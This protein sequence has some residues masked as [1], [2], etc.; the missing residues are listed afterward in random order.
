MMRHIRRMCYPVAALAVLTGPLTSFST[1][2]AD[3]AGTDPVRTV[4]RAAPDPASCPQRV[5]LVNGG[6]EQPAVTGG[7]VGFFPDASQNGVPGWVTTA[8]DHQIEL[9]TGPPNPTNAAPAEGRQFAELNANQVSTLYQ[10]H[11]TTP[12]A[13]LYWRLSHRGRLGVDT[14][15]LDI[16]APGSPVRQRTVSD[17]ATGWGA[18]TGTYTVPAGQTTT[19]FAFTSLSAAGGN[20]GIGNFL[21]DVFFGTAPC[22]VVTKTAIPDGPADVGDVITYRLTARNDGGAPA[23]NVRLTDA[24]PAGTSYLPGSLRVVDGPNT[25][26]KTDQ[27]GDDQGTFD[28]V[29][30]QVSFSLGAGATGSA[31]GR[32]PSTADLPDGT[33]VEFR[34]R[35][36][37]A[38]AGGRIVNQGGVSYDNR[39]GATPEPLRS[40]SGEIVT[41]VNPA[42]DLSVVKSADLTRV[43]VGQTVTYRLSV[44]NAGPNDA[45]GVAVADALPQGL[46]FVSAT[47]SSGAYDPATG[48]WTVGGLPRG[49][50]ATLTI[51]AKATAP[52]KE[53]NTATVGGNELDLDPA[54]DS[55]AVE[56]CV[57]PPPPC[58][59]CASPRC[60]TCAP[61]PGR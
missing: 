42:V 17:D 58:R 24:V 41:R 46:T 40:T 10:D 61:D 55:D 44:R 8:T 52:G 49:G 20:R 27:P 45:T 6:F 29:A 37:R 47:P 25:G 36:G 23:E 54:N 4:R 43:T 11:P 7:A 18:Y 50:A 28:P 15:A 34:V 32:L 12:G 31:N 60:T 13:T 14:M 53:T 38:A 51:H 35:V 56:V 26:V 59:N 57:E 33:T 1:S 19:R 39:L 5:A 22:V 2:H 48:K 9:W 16:G 21:D 3:A 30:N